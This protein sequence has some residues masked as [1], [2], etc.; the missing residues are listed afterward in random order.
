MTN[1]TDEPTVGETFHFLRSGFGYHAVVD[2]LHVS[3]VSRRGDE[4]TITAEFLDANRDR[5]GHLPPLLLLLH[6]PASQVRRWGHQIL[7]AGPKPDDLLRTVPGELDHE[8]SRRAA[9]REAKAIAGLDERAAAVASVQHRW[10]PPRQPAVATHASIGVQH[11][12][13]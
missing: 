6:D 4:V 13:R 12:D 8:E 1:E 9:M 11:G 3:L 2:R 5:Y 7:A 10:G